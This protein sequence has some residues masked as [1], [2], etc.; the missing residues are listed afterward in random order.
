MNNM[1]T[2]QNNRNNN[3]RNSNTGRAT[4]RQYQERIFNEE[5]DRDQTENDQNGN[6]R[7]LQIHDQNENG[8]QNIN[9]QIPDAPANREL[10]NNDGQIP[11]N[12]NVF[13]NANRRDIQN[14]NR[15]LRIMHRN[16]MEENELNEARDENETNQTQEQGR[17]LDTQIFNHNNQGLRNHHTNE[18]VNLEQR[19]C[20]VCM[21]EERNTVL[22]PCGHTH[23]CQN[24]VFMIARRNQTCPICQTFIQEHRRIYL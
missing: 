23:F 4:E 20:I 17:Q 7:V 12:N 8:H 1:R 10:N 24:C 9:S 21:E 19:L 3:N 16:A 11:V 22:F 15:N 13:H 14:L 5:L 2:Q 6:E 18:Q